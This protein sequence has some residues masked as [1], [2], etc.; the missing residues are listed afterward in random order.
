MTQGQNT[1]H[2]QKPATTEEDNVTVYD[3]FE[4]WIRE[5]DEQDTQKFLDH[6]AKESGVDKKSPYAFMF[7]GFSGGVHKGIEFTRRLLLERIAEGEA[8]GKNRAVGSHQTEKRTLKRE[9]VAFA[10]LK[11]LERRLYNAERNF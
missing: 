9:R 5:L 11:A 4:E 3:L 10:R 7:M 2:A 6:F 8:G 1:G